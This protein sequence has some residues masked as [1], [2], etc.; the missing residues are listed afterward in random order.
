MTQGLPTISARYR[1]DRE[2]GRGGMGSVYLGSDTVL[3]RRVAIKVLNSAHLDAPS[4]IPRFI[5]EGRVCAQLRSENCVKIFDL[6]VN[7]RGQ[8]YL[9]MELLEGRD[10]A[11]ELRTSGKVPFHLAASYMLQTCTALAEAHQLGV[12]HRDLKPHNLFLTRALPGAA[13][14]VKVLDFGLSRLPK[15]TA[16]TASGELLGTPAY[17]SP[18]QVEGRSDVDAR[19]DIWSLGVILYELVSG[20][21]PFAGETIPH[22]THRILY[23]Q[24]P[25]LSAVASGV[26]PG[27][28]AIVNR[29]MQKAAAARYAN[30]AE[31]VR[32][33]SAFAQP[34]AFRA[35][36]LP[37]PPQVHSGPPGAVGWG[38]AAP[39][40]AIQHP[41]SAYPAVYAATGDV[42]IPSF[43][44][45]SQSAT[46]GHGSKGTNLFLIGTLLGVGAVALAGLGVGG[47][48]LFL[49]E[50]GPVAAVASA[51]EAKP[52]A[53]GGTTDSSGVLSNGAQA[54]RSGSG[55]APGT[56]PPLVAPDGGRAS[57]TPGPTPVAVVDA[58][59]P[60]PS[61]GSV[62]WSTSIN[63]QGGYTYAL[64]HQKADGPII[65][66]AN[67]NQS[68]LAAA[69]PEWKK[70]VHVTLDYDLDGTILS[71]SAT[72]WSALSEILNPCLRAGLKGKS[73]GPP[74]QDSKYRHVSLDVSAK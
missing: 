50:D 42:S 35:S 61:T 44:S 55:T 58:G 69:H 12:V 18:E 45:T 57:P 52:K 4:A 26:P 23:E 49:H 37:A 51:P 48:F 10:L 13:D 68:K 28:D 25:P 34:P 17:M 65:A 15:N 14:V 22:T 24:P 21:R 56:L 43:S 31:L 19:A 63:Y 1:I 8:P 7:E 11:Q 39:H 16:L 66:C 9:V 5:Q 36:Y 27:F 72:G 2:I 73:L 3:D 54:P 33:L 46:V 59:A 29:C 41:G 70:G 30:V 40:A 62:V 47:Y 32:D 71:A 60:A 20:I 74:L 38:P 6:G 64:I 53:S 67:A